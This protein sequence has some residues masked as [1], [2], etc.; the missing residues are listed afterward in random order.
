LLSSESSIG[1]NSIPK[2]LLILAF[3]S[4]G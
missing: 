4:S 1:M 2:G 3:E